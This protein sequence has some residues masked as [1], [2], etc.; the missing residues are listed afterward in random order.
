MNMKGETMKKLEGKIAIVTAST[1]GI[2]YACV[3]TLAA[4][5]CAGLHGLPQH[6]AWPGEG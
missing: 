1:R 3:E 4:R 2:G 6:F 5:G